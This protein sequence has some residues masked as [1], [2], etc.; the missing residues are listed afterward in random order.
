MIDYYPQGAATAVV[1]LR[2][3][4]WGQRRGQRRGT[5]PQQIGGLGSF[6]CGVRVVPEKSLKNSY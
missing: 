5:H 6:N 1:N 4:E 3:I 2:N